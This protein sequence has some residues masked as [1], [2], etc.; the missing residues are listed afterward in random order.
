MNKL[1]TN[2][3]HIFL[4]LTLAFFASCN[5]PS[6]INLTSTNLSQNPSGIY[7]LQ[8]ELDIQDRMVSPE[9]IQ[10]FT[11]VGGESI[12][13]VQDP[14]NPNLWSCDYKLP[15]GFDEATY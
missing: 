13:M 15:P 5:Q 14:I 10:V 11:V 3:K 4:S 6:F 1:K 8:T 7:T 2:Y 12:P 9:T